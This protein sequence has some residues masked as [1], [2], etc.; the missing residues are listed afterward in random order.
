MGA[1][2]LFLGDKKVL[3]IDDEPYMVEILVDEMN[4]AQIP[5]ITASDGKKALELI[6]SEKPSLIVSDFQMPGLNGIE[7]LQYLRALGIG[8]PVIW[9]TGNANEKII[10]EA[11]R[12]GVFHIFE[13]PFDARD[14]SAEIIK[15]L[16]ISS[17]LWLTLKPKYLTDAFVSK[18]YAKIQIDLDKSTLDILKQRCLDDSQSI[19]SFVNSALREALAK[20]EGSPPATAQG[21][22]KAS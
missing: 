3:L 10:K 4:Q 17:D 18:H 13:K 14:V 21:Q 20:K 2:D 6:E 9:I 7:L 8:S 5:C 15:A 12:L 1:Q 19:N 11:W 22:R 16:R